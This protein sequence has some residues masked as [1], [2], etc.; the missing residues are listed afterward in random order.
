MLC[1]DIENNQTNKVEI[2][3]NTSMI[4][5]SRKFVTPV[6]Y[7][8][9]FSINDQILHKVFGKGRIINIE[10]FKRDRSMYLLKQ[11]FH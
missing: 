9:D 11:M 5:R 2:D 8:E 7:L 6:Q 4:Q 10:G 1:F 3:F